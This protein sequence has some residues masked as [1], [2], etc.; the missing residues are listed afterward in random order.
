MIAA[1]A[2]AA[3]LAAEALALYTFAELVAVSYSD[4]HAHA[5]GAWALVL[6]S[7][8]A[9][10]APRFTEGNIESPRRA[11]LALAGFAAV[12]LY[13]LV[14]IEFA[15]DLAL[16]DFGWVAGFLQDPEQ[17]LSNGAEALL[18]TVF[19]GAMWVR[20]SLRSSQEV[21]LDLLPR[22]VGVPFAAVTLFVVFGAMGDRAGEVGR[23]AAAFYACAVL[24]L[25]FSQLSRSGA[26][27]GDVRAGGVTAALLGGTAALVALG[28][29]VAGVLLAW[30]GPVLGPPLGAGLEYVLTIIVTPFAWLLEKFFAMLFQGHD[31]FSNFKQTATD[32]T[33][34]PNSAGNQ[35]SGW[36]LAGAYVVRGLALIV[37]AAIVGGVIWYVARLR[38]RM[39][40]REQQDVVTAA[41]GSIGEDA[42]ALLRGL[43]RRGQ[44]E[45]PIRGA[46]M[47]RLYREV[48]L[49]AERQGLDRAP[50]KT[51]SELAPALN[52][53]FRDPVTDEITWAFEQARYAGREPD[54]RTLEELRRRW[55]SVR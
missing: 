17:A 21:D 37:F 54:A 13:A 53:Q 4:V 11:Q 26:T 47:T 50:G 25:A 22:Q 24:A 38:R 14:R 44:P 48:L 43:F 15:G 2:I 39:K 8:A 19:L 7:L 46:G 49:K 27:I 55:G 1:L 29:L 20:S 42:R 51:P 35:E 3:S 30:L 52:D 18:G 16:W 6:V 23:A 36:Q 31:P 9:Y 45:Q 5:V 10:V 33:K 41:A 28:L 40:A 32:L 12:L 34:Q